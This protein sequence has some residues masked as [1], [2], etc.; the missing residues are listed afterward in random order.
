MTMPTF[1]DSWLYKAKDA[2][3][4]NA[5]QN[6]LIP[7]GTAER[8]SIWCKYTYAGTGNIRVQIAGSFSETDPSLGNNT[9]QNVVLDQIT[10]QNVVASIADNPRVYPCWW[11]LITCPGTA[12]LSAFNLHVA[13]FGRGPFGL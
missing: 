8:G 10:N 4:V 1:P 11:L 6:I 5:S 3:T 9:F 7:A 13:L 12:T 2:A